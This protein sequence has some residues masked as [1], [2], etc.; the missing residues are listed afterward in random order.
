MTPTGKPSARRASPVARRRRERSLPLT[1]AEAG[2]LKIV[3]LRFQEFRKAFGRA[4]GK[5]DP[6]FFVDGVS[7]PVLAAT[8]QI[9]EQLQ[10]AATDCRVD[11]AEVCEFLQL[12]R[13]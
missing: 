2:L 13:R 9:Y 4:P 8:S 7:T 6:L 11:F 10:A 1:S 5:L 3:S 12:E